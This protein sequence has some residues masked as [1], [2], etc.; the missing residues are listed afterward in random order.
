MIAHIKPVV[1]LCQQDVRR[2]LQLIRDR[3]IS[4]SQV[5]V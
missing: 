5:A 1:N 3:P 4:P 2:V